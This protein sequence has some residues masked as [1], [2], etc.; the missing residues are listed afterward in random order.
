MLAELMIVSLSYDAYRPELVDSGRWYGLLSY[1]GQIAK[2]LVAIL[3]FVL[4]GLLP[5]LPEH[6]HS[7]MRAIRT[8][9]FQYFVV[10]QLFAYAIFLWCTS[11]I[12]GLEVNVDD[13]SGVMVGVWLVM[14]I[15]TG[16]LWL[17]S[18][19][20]LGFWRN[21]FTSEIKVFLTALVVGIAAWVL[22]GYAE[23]LW[24]PLSDLTFSL[25]AYLL[26]QVYPDILVDAASKRLGVGTFIVN[27]APEC[28]GYEGM[29]LMVIFTAFY[30]SMF[31]KDFR[32]PQALLLFPIGIVTIW[33]FNIFRIVTLIS[34]GASF[35][36]AVAVG[37]FHSQA[38]WISFIVVIVAMLTLAYRMPF[39]SNVSQTSTSTNRHLT[40]PMTLLI[41]FIVL[42]ASTILT[43]ALSADFDWFYPLRVVAVALALGICWRVYQFTRPVFNFEPWLAGAVVFGLWILLVPDDA[44]QNETFAAEL[45]GAS[46]T[47]IVLWILFRF[48]GTVVTVPLA[49]ELLFRGYLLSRL[50]RCE[51][52][53]EG[54]IAF[55]WVALIA[56]SILFG[57]L[58]SAWLAG[59]AAGLIYGWVRYR[60]DSIKD[61]VIAHAFT[62][63]LLS[64]YVLSTGSWSLW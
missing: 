4:L 58:H 42:L 26:G 31:R 47:V 53:I 23:T 8:Y 25:S 51:V 3:V 60:G 39:F 21:L 40:L 16:V 2:V 18:F 20:P 6:F 55:S 61:A 5:R 59:I 7:L 54:R 13:I 34:I 33:F 15:T 28:S 49:E 44:A 56:S 43:S 29:G 10:L 46:Q 32:F 11:L 36:P 22:A 12:F 35:S 62:N 63:L 24:A 57:L 17:L 30:L 45:F 38:G 27:I 52:T 64:V 50:A 19:A 41:P 1:A 9:P 37:G 14:L 48:L